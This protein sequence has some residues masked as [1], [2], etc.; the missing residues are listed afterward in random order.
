VNGQHD[1]PAPKCNVKV[2]DSRLACRGHWYQLPKS[3][4][5]RIWAFYIP[6]QTITT[7]SPEYRVALDDAIA[8]W[9]EHA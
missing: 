5:D 6:G 8:Y 4:R 9:G 7:M 2:G 3:I 1:C